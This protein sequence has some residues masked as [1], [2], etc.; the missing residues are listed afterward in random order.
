MVSCAVT[1]VQHR[2]Y[3]KPPGRPVDTKKIDLP[4]LVGSAP[5]RSIS[6]LFLSRS[7]DCCKQAVTLPR[8]SRVPGLESMNLA[9]HFHLYSMGGPQAHGNSV[10]ARDRKNPGNLSANARYP[11]GYASP[12]GWLLEVGLRRCKLHG[13]A[14]FGQDFQ[15]FQMVLHF[16]PFLSTQN[17]CI[18]QV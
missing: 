1:T 14:V 10:D 6:N 13:L 2:P 8:K 5:R 16:S 17:L 9:R 4:F 3:W 7:N 18:S 12:F 15:G 11:V